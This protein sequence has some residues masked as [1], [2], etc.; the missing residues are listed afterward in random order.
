MNYDNLEIGISAKTTSAVNSIKKLSDS[1]STLSSNLNKVDA[2]KFASL[3]KGMQDLAT[4]VT[5]LK[6]ATQGGTNNIATLATNL[7]SLSN[8]SASAL[9]GVIGAIK[10]LSDSFATFGISG[11]AISSI[12]TLSNSLAQLGG[13]NVTK[14]VQGMG[15]LTVA[16]KNLLTEISKAPAV[17]SNVIKLIDS[18]ARLT[19]NGQKVSSTANS[20]GRA[21]NTTSKSTFRL[22]YSFRGI[23]S[24]IGRLYGELWLLIRAVKSLG[25]AIKSAMSYGETLNY[26]EKAFDDIASRSTEDWKNLGYESA[27]EYYQALSDTLKAEAKGINEQL[28]G[29]TS[30]GKG[31]QVSTNKNLG[32]NTTDTLKAQTR[33]AQMSASMGVATNNATLLSNVMTKLGG[34]L[35]SLY[36]TDFN[37]VWGNLQSGLA[38][39]SRVMD[40]YGVNVR[41][42]NLNQTLLE[43]GIDTT[44]DKLGQEDK[45]LLRTIVMLKG[46]TSAWGDLAE[47]LNSNAN[48]LRLL[49][50]NWQKLTTI[51]G[52]MFAPVLQKILPI[53]NA[54]VVALQRLASFVASL[55]GIEADFGSA[56][57]GGLEDTSDYLD[58]IGDSADNASGA[59]KKLK[60][61]LLGLDELN[62][63]SSKDNSGGGAGGIGGAGGQ[64][65][66]AFLKATQE[67]LDAWQ[68]AF[69]NMEDRISRIADI[70]TNSEAF[71]TLK[72]L[73]IDL[74]D[75]DWSGVGQDISKLFTISVD[76]ITDLLKSIDWTKVGTNIGKFL[77]GLDFS[78]MFESINRLIDTI[79][80]GGLDLWVASFTEAP[81]ETALI[82]ALG[83]C[84]FT[85][86]GK[87]FL[88]K[89][90]AGVATA[91]VG[92]DIGKEISKL[93]FG[94][95]DGDYDVTI[96]DLKIIIEDTG[97]SATSLQKMRNEHPIIYSI[98]TGAMG[99]VSLPLQ[100][101]LF[102]KD[103]ADVGSWFK[104]HISDPINGAIN[105]YISPIPKKI[106]GIWEGIVDFINPR[107]IIEG[108]AEIEEGVRNWI[109]N[110]ITPVID[111]FKNLLKE[112]WRLAFLYIAGLIL[113]IFSKDK[114]TNNLNGVKTGFS[115]VLATVG[116]NT[117][118]SLASILDS[119]RTWFSSDKV[120]SKLS[121][122][123]SGFTTVMNTAKST[124]ELIANAI[125]NAI[126]AI[127]GSSSNF[128]FNGLLSAFTSPFTSAISYLNDII[129]KINQINGM[130]VNVSASSVA[131]F[132][133]NIINA[134]ADVVKEETK[135]TTTTTTYKGSK[136]GMPTNIPKFAS[137]GIPNMGSLFW[138]GEAGPE[139]VGTIGG[140]NTTA[141]ASNGEI[142]GISDTIRATSSAEMQ[143]LR[144]QNELL[145]QIVAKPM[146]ITESELFNSV[147]KSAKIYTQMTGNLAF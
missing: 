97:I 56:I 77:E 55:F 113:N 126:N 78:G 70:I 123:T 144:Q 40:K 108:L 111:N 103:F 22:H 132:G 54:V 110:N 137:G 6:S 131:D 33:F 146:G 34:D 139:L 27:T 36:D 18:M 102:V 79:I 37:S 147:R 50:G 130:Q 141:V 138:A 106:E 80:M 133:A 73:F 98:L 121:G 35:A 128:T 48:Q 49:Q 3:S 93:I 4:G 1:L 74:K 135:K 12:S 65:N 84:T 143:L 38:G 20:I 7:K 17:N 83:V 2:S 145:M 58:G 89:V 122:I 59:V 66:E 23:S 63:I 116:I 142:T 52:S 60:N 67:Y 85:G 81:L 72:E 8:L 124:V 5:A 96:S 61:Q 51:I 47:T 15:N 76:G 112:D 82:T 127:F 24:S 29:M 129:N 53:I 14:A 31:F 119:I 92:F 62:V 46:T 21:F 30:N 10:K 64:L 99:I 117:S 114:V 107:E 44:V 19:A 43:L 88:G 32:L 136:A 39:M 109:D 75:G 140:S 94:E 69:D 91:L 120:K 41:N 42:A 95:D 9:N 11:Q 105:K 57:G 86:L 125:K 90:V 13:A 26:F 25:S 115:G 28:T 87:A 45:V 100:L 16:L 71:K 134:V 101:E 104:K 118:T 68:T